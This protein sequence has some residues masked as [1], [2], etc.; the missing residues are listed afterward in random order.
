VDVRSQ[1]AA[2][3]FARNYA[4]YWLIN[5]QFNGQLIPDMLI[6]IAEDFAKLDVQAVPSAVI[7]YASEGSKRCADVKF[8]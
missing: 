2:R 1:W 8:N 3:I 5:C 6:F 7:F 4:N